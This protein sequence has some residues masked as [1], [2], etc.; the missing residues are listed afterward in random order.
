MFGVA[1]TC[2]LAAACGG[3]DRHTS[4]S[5][6][7][8]DSARSIPELIQHSDAV[9]RGAVDQVAGTGYDSTSIPNSKGVPFTEF[10]FK[11]TDW[12]RGTGPDTIVLHQSGGPAEDGS[13]FEL[14]D[15]PL[16]RVGESDVLFLKESPSGSYY[17]VA[18]PT[19]RFLV[20]D[21]TARAMPHGQ[22]QQD[23]PEP[24]G[25]LIRQI[26]ASH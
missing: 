8:A 9:V 2:A 13:T 17:V 26:Q 20:S 23:F 18:G 16:F 6:S 4:T 3:V 21:K 11:V 15:D 12:I 25:D 1:T 24:V 10:S 7:W 19:G 5:A 14:D 22:V